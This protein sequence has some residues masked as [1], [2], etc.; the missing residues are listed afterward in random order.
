M[1]LKICSAETLI[2]DTTGLGPARAWFPRIVSEAFLEATHDGEMKISPDPVTTI[3]GDLAWFNDSGAD[4]DV[5]VLVHQAPR[6]IVAQ[7]PAQ[8]VVH[9]AW[10]WRVGVS[11]SADYPS[12]YQDTFGGRLQ[13]DRSSAAAD[14]LLY[15]RYFLDGDDSQTYQP[16]GVVPDGQA[17]HFRYLAAVQTPGTWTRPTEF[18]ARWEASARWCRLIALASPANLGP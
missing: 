16:V 3:D 6:S 2:S 1:S 4:Q 12:V 17:L 13:I 8:V 18:D 15:G 14:K 10:T 9:S 11:P 5:A 7:S